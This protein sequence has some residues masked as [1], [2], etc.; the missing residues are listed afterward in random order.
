M[1]KWKRSEVD[2]RKS[3][4]GAV[5]YQ[6]GQ[7]IKRKFFRTRQEREDFIAENGG[8]EGEQWIEIQELCREH[9]LN[10][11]QAIKDYIRDKFPDNSILINDAIIDC[12]EYKHKIRISKDHES[13]LIGFLN[14][15]GD[16]HK[17]KYVFQ[18]NRHNIEDWLLDK[19]NQPT[20]FR[21]YRSYLN[22]LFKYCHDRGYIRENP[23]AKIA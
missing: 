21:N 10:P 13:H 3:P 11:L 12:L 19:T 4:W 17:G 22:D 7:R 8:I 20:T 1:I 14:R 16:E 2:C 9:V 23:I 5:A 18:F 6:N 15:F